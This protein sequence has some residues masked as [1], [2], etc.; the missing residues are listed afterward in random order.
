MNQ[1]IHPP[2]TLTG[3]VVTGA[4]RGRTLGFPTANLDTA[5]PSTVAYGI[6]A[7]WVALQPTPAVRV[8]AV[9]YWGTRSTFAGHEPVV[10]VYALA[11]TAITYD[12]AVTITVTAFIRPDRYF[13]SSAELVA[14]MERDVV[15]ARTALELGPERLN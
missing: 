9:I 1:R 5:F 15:A 4:G 2:L 8:P 14:Q 7:G 13:A 10:E 6:Y 3:R 12:K 11:A